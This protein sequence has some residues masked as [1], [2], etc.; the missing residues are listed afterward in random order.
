MI[1]PL[2]W[3][4]G[5]VTREDGLEA[6]P[7]ELKVCA[8]DGRAADGKS[9]RYGYGRGGGERDGEAARGAGLFVGARSGGHD[10]G[11]RR[12][13]D[14]DRVAC[15]RADYVAAVVGRVER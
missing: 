2:V 9:E 10:R 15:L 11:R 5:M 3:P 7:T 12:A 4:A 13:V 1:V 6:R 14:G 8:T